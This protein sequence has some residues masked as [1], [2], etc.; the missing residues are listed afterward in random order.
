VVVPRAGVANAAAG[1]AHAAPWV[2]ALRVLREVSQQAVRVNSARLEQTRISTRRLRLNRLVVGLMPR[3]GA[4][5][6]RQMLPDLLPRNVHL[7][8]NVRP[9]LCPHILCPRLR[10]INLLRP[11]HSLPELRF[12]LRRR[13]R[14]R[15]PWC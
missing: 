10:L 7:L 13:A 15:A 2:E 4:Q 14:A 9:R 12:Q 3:R 8:R 6:L 1:A 5:A 11:C